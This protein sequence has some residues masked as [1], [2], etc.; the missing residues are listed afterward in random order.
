MRVTVA[1]R[2]GARHQEAAAEALSCGLREVGHAP[3]PT[4]GRSATTHHVICWGWR[5]ALDFRRRGHDVL[6]VERGYIGD[7]HHWHSLAWNGLN[8]RGKFPD[9]H[10]PERFHSQ[11]ELKPWHKGDYILVIGQVPGD[12]SLQGRDLKKWYQQ[13]ADEAKQ[14][15]R[16]PVVFRP[17]PVAL[18]R[19][20]WVDIKGCD[21]DL[22]PLDKALA[23]A[24]LCITYNSNAAVDALLAG[25]PTIT[26]DKGSMAW[27]VAGQV[28]VGYPKKD[29][30][31]W[32]ERLACKQWSLDEIAGGE[33]LTHLM[34][35][36]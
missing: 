17:H 23:K 7:R 31:E 36:V 34:G 12:M 35:M 10:D 26:T 27:D 4:H 11:W 29:R 32:A 8:N 5:K 14:T 2:P 33:P 18:E 19:G 30:T 16:L 28:L 6:V 13:V 22:G 20:N 25:V 24:A 15:Y 1:I 21:T 3:V 9:L